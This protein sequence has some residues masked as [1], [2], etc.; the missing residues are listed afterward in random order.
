VDLELV[1]KY[2]CSY[3]LIISGLKYIPELFSGEGQGSKDVSD[4]IENEDMLDTATDGKEKPEEDKNDVAEEDNGIEMSDDFDSH[5]Q[6]ATGIFTIFFL[7]RFRH[8]R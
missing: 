3:Y 4:Q 8:V 7:P 2:Q 1:F 5:L 6:V